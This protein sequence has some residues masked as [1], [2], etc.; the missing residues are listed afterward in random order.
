MAIQREQGFITELLI[1]GD[2]N[3]V[4]D[5]QISSKY[6]NGR[7]K[8]AFRFI[9]QHQT[10]YGK[11]PSI[12]T[13]K[14]KFPNIELAQINGEYSTGENIQF[15]CDQLR[16]KKK[17]NTIVDSLDEVL[18]KINEDLDTEGAY[19]IL[20][21]LVLQVE[22]ELV[23]SDRIKINEDTYKRKE[24]Y[25][26]RQKSGGMTGIPSFIDEWDK[27]LGGYNNGE[28]ITFMGYTGLGKLV[29]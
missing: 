9:Q 22:N 21:K 6:L 24:D 10:Q 17:H 27:L 28:L 1:T 16:E 11:V 19:N 18:V 8:K 20:K 14:K 13:F 2:M 29:A 15:W 26:K 4:V 3:T 23:L 12:E 25:K 7:Y 5:N